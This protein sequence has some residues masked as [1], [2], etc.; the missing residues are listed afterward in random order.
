MRSAKE[1]GYVDFDS[2]VTYTKVE[3]HPSGALISKT[4]RTWKMKSLKKVLQ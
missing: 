4:K 1:A 3:I 2:L